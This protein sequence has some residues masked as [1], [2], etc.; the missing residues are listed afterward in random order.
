[1]F[2]VCTRA[3][4]TKM[5]TSNPSSQGRKTPLCFLTKALQHAEKGERKHMDRLF[6]NVGLSESLLLSTHPRFASHQETICWVCLSGPWA[7]AGF[8][9]FSGSLQLLPAWPG[10]QGH[11]QTLSV[12]AAALARGPS[13][14]SLELCWQG[15]HLCHLDLLQLTIKVVRSNPNLSEEL[16]R[17]L[18]PTH[19]CGQKT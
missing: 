9:L 18:S 16:T 1:M 14:P 6:F 17:S 12:Q 19:L 4:K 7:K 15:L 11:G 3:P 5:R 2:F 10:E 13:A 8:R